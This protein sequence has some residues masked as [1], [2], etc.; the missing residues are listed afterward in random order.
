[1]K[2]TLCSIMTLSSMY[3]TTQ[4]H[5][6]IPLYQTEDT[7]VYANV[8]LVLGT[9]HSDKIIFQYKNSIVILG[10]KVIYNMV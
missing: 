3:L 2:K 9:F 1:M 8:S 6:D 5:A 10:R 4:T 7:N